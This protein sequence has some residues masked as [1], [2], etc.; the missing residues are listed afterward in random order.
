[1]FHSTL[2]DQL[3]KQVLTNAK[4]I[5]MVGVSSVKKEETSTI[6]RRRP[7]I[8]VMKYLQEFGY[9]VVPVNPFSVGKKIHGE[10][11]V[12]KLEDI[13]IPVDI[14]DVFRPS[15]EAPIIAKQAVKIEAKVLWLQFGIQNSKAQE[16]AKLADITCIQNRCIKQEYQRLFLKTSPVFPV[17][18]SN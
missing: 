11:I 14:V 18:L 13:T 5:A 6:V 16:I 2:D 12:A 3:I 1:M 4:T 9:R 10:T 8:I 15:Q 17:L 7:S